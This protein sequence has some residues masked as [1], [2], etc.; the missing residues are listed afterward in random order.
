[1]TSA[2]SETRGE[3]LDE[4]EEVIDEATVG[5]LGGGR[6]GRAVRSGRRLSGSSQAAVAPRQPNASATCPVCGMF[7]APHGNW[8]AQVIFEDG[9]A[10]FFDGA[11]DLFKYLLE[12]PVPAR[13]RA[14]EIAAT[15]VTGYYRLEAVPAAEAFFVVGSDVYGPMGPELIPHP[16]LAEAEE[17]LRD[18]GGERIVRFDEVTAEA[19]HPPTGGARPGTHHGGR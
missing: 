2:A 7:V 4:C 16:T 15:F 6:R 18:H 19:A 14:L 12:R 17:F 8:V 9:S 1:M 10:A 11:K 13:L 3:G 5:N